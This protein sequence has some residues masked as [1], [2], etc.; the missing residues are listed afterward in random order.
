MYKY[1]IRKF[2]YPLYNKLVD[3]VVREFLPCGKYNPKL[4]LW[5]QRGND[6][7]RHRSRLNQYKPIGD[8]VVLV[9]GCGSGR[10]MHSWLKYRPKKLIG[11]D[12]FD[13]QAEWSA[14]KEFCELNSSTEVE[15][16]KSSLENLE[17]IDSASVDIVSSDAVLEHVVDL[18]SV[19]KSITRVLKNDGIFY[20]TYGPLWFSYGGDHISGNDDP[21]NGYNHLILDKKSYK[22]Y[23]DSF[24]PYKH[25]EDDG[26]T[27]VYN[28]L[29]SK[30]TPREYYEVFSMVGLEVIYDQLL[31]DPRAYKQMKTR[32]D[33]FH[34]MGMDYFD[35]II[36]A[37]TV[38]CRKK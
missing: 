28:N 7:E 27:W 24:G 3:I 18:P 19:L 25:D 31:I 35:N 6:Y 22:K 15:F 34:A 14:F 5:G 37:M 9:A 17:M 1:Y 36:S 33:V 16:Y 13:Y 29:F 32:K 2:I 8:C 30:L 4:W 26:R 20:S 23:L 11:I 12:L 10:D 21:V 38:I